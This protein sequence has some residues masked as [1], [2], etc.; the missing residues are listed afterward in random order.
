MSFKDLYFDK[1][2]E[3]KMEIGASYDEEDG[4]PPMSPLSSPKLPLEIKEAA[5]EQARPPIKKDDVVSPLTVPK[6]EQAKK[7]LPKQRQQPGGPR[8]AQ[9]PRVA[10]GVPRAPPPRRSFPPLSK[11]ST[12]QKPTQKIEEDDDSTDGRR[13]RLYC[14]GMIGIAV[15]IVGLLMYGAFLTAVLVTRDSSETLL[16]PPTAVAPT[17]VTPPVPTYRPYT[18]PTRRPTYQ[19]PPTPYPTLPTY[20]TT[21]M[22][23]SAHGPTTAPTHSA[24]YEE[25][26]EALIALHAGSVGTL[27]SNILA[28]NTWL[29]NDDHCTWQGVR[30]S[31]SYPAPR[32]VTSLQLENFGMAGT[33]ASEVG[34][35][36]SLTRLDVASNNLEGPIP[37]ELGRLTALRYLELNSNDLTGTVPAALCNLS[38]T[39]SADCGGDEPPVTC[40]CCS[41]CS[42]K[43]TP[44]EQ[45]EALVA[46]YN[47]L[48]GESWVRNVNWLQGD[49][50]DNS[51]SGVGCTRETK[52]IVSLD[53][54][55][56]G[57]KGALPSEI[58][59]LTRLTNLDIDRNGITGTIPSEIGLMT[60]LQYLHLDSNLLT[61]EIP[62]EFG[63]LR[64]IRTINLKNNTLEGSLPSELSN[65]SSMTTFD[66]SANNF[67]GAA[68]ETICRLRRSRLSSFVSD[69]GGSDPRFECLC[70]TAC[71][72]D[73]TPESQVEAL[74]AFYEITSYSWDLEG[75][76]CANKWPR[77]EC[78]FSKEITHIDMNYGY[79]NGTLPTEIG[80]LT[81]LVFVDLS[82]NGLRG[83]L[84]TEIAGLS[85][86]TH[87]NLESNLLSGTMPSEL[88]RLTQL[89][90]F[91]AHNNLFSNAIP[92][93]IG[94]LENLYS[95]NLGQNLLTGSMPDE[96]CTLRNS[97]LSSLLAD[98]GGEAEVTCSCCT[99]C[100]ADAAP[101]E[102][103][104][105]LKM[106][107][108]QTNGPSW[109]FAHQYQDC[110]L[111]G[112][113]C[114]EGWQG[115][116]C[117][118]E[119]RV[120][121]LNL[122]RI[123]MRGPL[124]TEIG[125][126][127]DLGYLRLGQNTLTG[128]Y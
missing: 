83:T 119:K 123:G 104:R 128:K 43:S 47:S 127:T 9:K 55:F 86:L 112:D 65:L 40:T 24:V 67:T 69:C 94:K 118:T 117:N 35:L 25:E 52:N 82:S 77:I 10:T 20:Y 110:W 58:G 74:R 115:V 8:P 70:C 27:W 72:V 62:S 99:R 106:L 17:T 29:R 5:Q 105:A 97:R 12:T 44:D 32:R 75:D 51:W 64:S 93:E 42:V 13:S 78:D 53:L 56:Q 48:S 34:L 45:R 18:P 2:E 3:S 108:N 126:L 73:R 116:T 90:T 71:V 22:P 101:A 113:P 63:N 95:L 21:P 91:N 79:L 39:I 109:N 122:E 111:M 125:L 96:I 66:I 61:G 89:S 38:R 33:L 30:C 26:K 1:N 120:T 100:Y 76:P 49:P 54:D 121:G 23:S 14:Y 15:V 28:R 46:L 124:P 16:S 41:T 85:K 88:Q 36:R 81:S 68:D 80:M 31:S 19:R 4:P 103:V 107:H 102:Q 7:P 92:S 11:P 98:C 57:L 37:S 84:P 6:L 87:L 59:S 60:S 50:C 114:V